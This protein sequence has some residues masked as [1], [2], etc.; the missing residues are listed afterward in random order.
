M[1]HTIE[2]VLFTRPVLLWL[3][4]DLSLLSQTASIY[5]N[6]NMQYSQSNT[7]SQTVNISS[8][9]RSTEI[10]PTIRRRSADIPPTFRRQSAVP[11]TC[12]TG[13]LFFGTDVT[14]AGVWYI[15]S[16]IN[17]A[18]VGKSLVLLPTPR[19]STVQISVCHKTVSRMPLK[20]TVIG[21]WP[22]P[23]YLKLGDWF[24][25]GQS[26][27]DFKIWLINPMCPG[28]FPL[29]DTICL[30]LFIFCLECIL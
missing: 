28:L 27:L 20:T 11:P 16:Y 6:V 24:Q 13:I 25:S 14:I 29:P 4:A 23:D 26:K 21:A 1:W 22:K 15:E 17:I 18:I 8:L 5:M 19:P 3:S 30:S 10:P 7:S 12:H 2:L 9:R